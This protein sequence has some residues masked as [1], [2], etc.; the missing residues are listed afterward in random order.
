LGLINN[1]KVS[2]DSSSND[3]IE[4][5]SIDSDEEDGYF[6]S[7]FNWDLYT[8]LKDNRDYSGQEVIDSIKVKEASDLELHI[9]HQVIRAER[10]GKDVFIA[11]AM[12]NLPLMMFLLLPIFALLLKLLY[13]RRNILYIKHLIHAL[14][15]HCFAYLIYGT[16]LLVSF[17]LIDNEVM[18]AFVNI[19]SFI[20]VS[21][22]AYISFLHVYKQ[23]WLKTL[24]KFN[25]QGIIYSTVLSIFFLGELF[26]SFLLF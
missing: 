19:F 7:K 22:Y 11:Y 10:D 24:I 5:V 25:I 3:S 16:S 2:I 9:M 6:F 14:H 18:A 1:P 4:L 21:T 13:I 17:Y 23:H 15:L 8:E 12:K 26:I 20:L